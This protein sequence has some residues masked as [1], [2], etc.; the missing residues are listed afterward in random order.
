M[1]PPAFQLYADDFLAGTADM[2][3]EEVG[4][5]IRLLCHAWNKH[6][7]ENDE[8]RLGLLAGQCHGNAAAE[9]M[10]VLSRKFVVAPDGR[11]RNERQ[12][13]TRQQMILYRDQQSEKARIRWERVQMAKNTP[14]HVN[15]C[16]GIATA[17]PVVCSPSPSP[18]PSPIGQVSDKALGQALEGKPVQRTG[19]VK[20]G[21]MTPEG[22][23]AA[24]GPFT[25]AQRHIAESFER[26]LSGQW[27]NDAG[28]WILR[29]RGATAKCERVAAEVEGAIREKRIKTTPA[30]Y[31][32]QIWKEFK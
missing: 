7:L 11:W 2:T 25:E 8:K 31:A 27:L 32:E 1:K 28:K 23:R 17:L 9:A 19:G 21:A 26:N 4:V 18:T 24:K 10:Q 30:Q 15:G 14:P 6:G 29:I 5:Y 12:E 3:A 16:H 13:F 20:P 22:I